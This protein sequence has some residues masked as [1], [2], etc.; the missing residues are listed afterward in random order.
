VRQ[1]KVVPRSSDPWRQACAARRPRLPPCLCARAAQASV[2]ASPGACGGLRGVSLPL[3]WAECRYQQ[4]AP[5]VRC[6][7]TSAAARLCTPS[8]K[9]GDDV[10]AGS[11][12]PPAA[13]EIGGGRLVGNFLRVRT[14]TAV[15]YSRKIKSCVRHLLGLMRVSGAL[16]PRV[17]YQQLIDCVVLTLLL[18]PSS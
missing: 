5:P 14:A 16:C 13:D 17:F 9:F 3:P 12:L 11:S 6:T 8:K 4:Q 18:C 7:L 15:S 2:A 1:G 10:A